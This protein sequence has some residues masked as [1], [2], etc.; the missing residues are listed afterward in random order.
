MPRKFFFSGTFAIAIITTV[1][2]FYTGHNVNHST[3]YHPTKP[4]SI[5]STCNVDLDS[6]IQ[7]GCIG[8]APR[9]P[10]RLWPEQDQLDS[11][12]NV[13][14]SPFLHYSSLSDAAIENPAYL[15]GK[16]SRECEMHCDWHVSK[17]RIDSFLPEISILPIIVKWTVDEESLRMA[18]WQQRMALVN[19][20]PIDDSV[21]LLE[22]LHVYHAQQ[23]SKMTV[24]R[25]SMEN[26]T[27]V[28]NAT[29]SY[30]A[31]FNNLWV[32]SGLPT[33]FH[34]PPARCYQRFLDITQENQNIDKNITAGWQIGV[35]RNIAVTTFGTNY[36]S[37]GI[38]L[39]QQHSPSFFVFA[40]EVYSVCPANVPIACWNG[41]IP[42]FTTPTSVTQPRGI[43]VPYLPMR[44]LQL[45]PTRNISFA[46]DRKYDVC[47]RGSSNRPTHIR[48]HL[49]RLFQGIRD[50][51]PNK[52]LLFQSS[53]NQEQYVADILTCKTWI[54]PYGDTHT[55]RHLSNAIAAGAV[56]IIISDSWILPF[57]R[58]LDWT[59][60]SIR[61]PEKYMI[62]SP[63][64]YAADELLIQLKNIDA[65]QAKLLTIRESLLPGYF[66]EYNCPVLFEAYTAMLEKQL[67]YSVNSFALLP[68]YVL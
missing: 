9:C 67:A 66:D 46:K 62:H 45:V 56:P 31:T 17:P 33:E 43:S 29:Y 37:A 22:M 20:A 24:A 36:G 18:G 64:R 65:L 30:C 26:E 54:A 15:G 50:I 55:C 10:S 21:V 13:S 16:H 53:S 40:D 47:F 6:S 39:R 42:P 34:T 19:K 51:D 44:A 23:I 63:E 7:A 14:V 2:V 49:E 60:F 4:L 61:I 27:Y 3:P 1:L 28:V 48:K 8:T 68:R 35:S 11:I 5:F 38:D 12:S 59:K 32:A 41:C 58:F 57:N 52:S 25:N